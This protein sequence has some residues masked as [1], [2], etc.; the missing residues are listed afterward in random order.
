MEP[1]E[2]YSQW[3]SLL[4]H[5]LGPFIVRRSRYT[6]ELKDMPHSN[7]C[8]CFG[9]NN[10]YKTNC[11][12]STAMN[13]NGF[14]NGVWKCHRPVTLEISQSMQTDQLCCSSW[15]VDDRAIRMRSCRMCGQARVAFIKKK[16][17]NS[18]KKWKV[19]SS[20]RC[21]ALC[22]AGWGT[23]SA[24]F[25]WFSFHLFFLGILLLS[26]HI[27]I[28]SFANAQHINRLLLIVL[29]LASLACEL[30]FKTRCIALL[31]ICV[32]NCACAHM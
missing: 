21:C 7:Y 17:R 30:F 24:F 3:D 19:A 25:S 26:L 12:Q 5:H 31:C 1:N 6:T 32:Y 22:L 29:Y 8:K 27:V 15:C 9:N 2:K 23:C 13:H 10:K 11:K 4:T 28:I 16:V 18:S 14:N 20:Q